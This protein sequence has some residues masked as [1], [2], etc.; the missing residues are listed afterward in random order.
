MQQVVQPTFW[1]SRFCGE[2][3]RCPA[4]ARAFLDL[5]LKTSSQLRLVRF[6]IHCNRCSAQ[7]NGAFPLRSLLEEVS[8]R[9]PQVGAHLLFMPFGQ[10][11]GDLHRTFST[12]VLLSSSSRVS[13]R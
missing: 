2:L 6:R 3:P 1:H 12:A 5:E 11:P 8:K 4:G 13:K 10:F 7:H 9:S